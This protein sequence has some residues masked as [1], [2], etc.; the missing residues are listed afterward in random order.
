LGKKIKVA[1]LFTARRAV[2]L[3]QQALLPINREESL[4]N[5]N[6]T[7]YKHLRCKGKIL[8]REF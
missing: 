2:V 7:T 4:K 8:E 6:P 3:N 5:I 1:V